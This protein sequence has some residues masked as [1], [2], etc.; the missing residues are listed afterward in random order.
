LE[1]RRKEGREGGREGKG[2][3]GKGREGKGREGGKKRKK[4]RKKERKVTL[5]GRAVVQVWRSKDNL[6]ES[7]LGMVARATP[8]SSL[9]GL[10]SKPQA[11]FFDS[12]D[13]SWSRKVAATK[14]KQ[15]GPTE[16]ES[17][18]MGRQSSFSCRL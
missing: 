12:T 2:R 10:E 13:L 8:R 7:L 6:G 5:G 4:E 1:E 15:V 17:H 16:V 14:R 9:L 3:E 11:Q 18:S